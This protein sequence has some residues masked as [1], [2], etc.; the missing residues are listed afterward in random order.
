MALILNKSI[1]GITST[2][3]FGNQLT[4]YTNLDYTDLYG[5]IH[6]NPY[7]VIDAVI[8]N[9]LAKF[10]KIYVSIYK[11]KN[12]RENKKKS[13]NENEYVI[14]NDSAYDNYFSISNME[15]LNVFAASYNYINNVYSNW[16]SDY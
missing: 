2:D 5:N 7:L 12:S 14:N 15:N 16:K 6:E 9:K 1:T 13:V 8:F 10:C 11:D 3:E 4:G